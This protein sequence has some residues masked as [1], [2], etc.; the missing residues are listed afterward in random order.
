MIK[1]PRKFAYNGPLANGLGYIHGRQRW[2]ISDGGEPTPSPTPTPTP[3]PTSMV[4]QVNF[5][6]PEAIAGWTDFQPLDTEMALVNPEGNPTGWT[7]AH[8]PIDIYIYSLGKQTGDNSG[9]APDPILLTYWYT[10]TTDMLF[11]FRGLDPAKTYRIEL[12]PSRDGTPNRTTIYKIGGVEIS[13]LADNNTND[14]A[15]F[16][17]VSPNAQGVIQC[18]FGRAEGTSHAYLNAGKIS[19]E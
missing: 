13:K 12:L 3:S 7:V 11:E 16:T 4:A 9:F 15:I 18:A 14:P 8:V 10:E 17:G 6:G 19:E 1:R 5:G 2:G